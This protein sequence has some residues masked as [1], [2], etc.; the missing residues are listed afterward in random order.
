MSCAL[1]EQ[2]HSRPLG[3]AAGDI[4]PSS[5]AWDDLRPSSHARP[6]WEDAALGPSARAHRCGGTSC[7][8]VTKCQRPRWT[9]SF[10][11]VIT[12]PRRRRG[13]KEAGSYSFISDE[14]GLRMP[15]Q[16]SLA[17]GDGWGVWRFDQL[18]ARAIAGGDAR[19]RC[20]LEIRIWDTN[21]SCAGVRMSAV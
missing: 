18:Q 8:Y 5:P 4:V 15:G 3:P 1:C 7:M 6:S 12:G 21:F 9:G 17:R 14:G 16:P 20:L 10:H 19:M 13:H 11:Q 2:D